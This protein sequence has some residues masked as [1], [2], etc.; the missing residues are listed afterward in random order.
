MD[1]IDLRK[2]TY[3]YDVKKKQWVISV[4]YGHVNYSSN[5]GLAVHL[6]F[7]DAY[8]VAKKAKKITGNQ[9]TFY[10]QRTEFDHEKVLRTEFRDI[11]S[12]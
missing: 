1:T 6:T 10:Q 5:R 12:L 3:L 11:C 8:E 9:L 4:G 7:I 2:P